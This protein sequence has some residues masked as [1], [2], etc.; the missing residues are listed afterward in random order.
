MAAQIKLKVQENQYK[1]SFQN[2]AC[3]L[4]GQ[5]ESV[6]KNRITR[7]IL[8][9]STFDYIDNTKPTKMIVVTDGDIAKNEYHNGRIYPMNIWEREHRRL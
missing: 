3:L 9:D 7:A 1:N 2:V 6:Y 5:F 4:E 8:E